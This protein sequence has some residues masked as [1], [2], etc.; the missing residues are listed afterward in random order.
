MLPPP[1][2]IVTTTP[3]PLTES[4]TI[5][6]TSS[7]NPS[8]NIQDENIYEIQLIDKSGLL[9]KTINIPSGAK[10]FNLNVS[11]FK[12]DIYIVRCF[13]GKEWITGQIIKK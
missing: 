4:T 11:S 12:N 1:S 13:N 8:N 7:E 3:N 10:S 6:L 9:L 2:L 5:K